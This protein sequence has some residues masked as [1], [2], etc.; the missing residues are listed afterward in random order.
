MPHRGGAW[1]PELGHLGAGEERPTYSDNAAIRNQLAVRSS[2]ESQP[3]DNKRA[4]AS[5]REDVGTG[6]LVAL[7]ALGIDDIDNIIVVAA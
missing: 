2:A 5:S 1:L 4:H 6:G 7:V 3:M